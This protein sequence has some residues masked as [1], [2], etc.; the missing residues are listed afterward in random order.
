MY[1]HWDVPRVPWGFEKFNDKVWRETTRR[2]KVE[3]IDVIDVGL[4]LSLYDWESTVAEIL[5][6]AV[7]CLTWRHDRS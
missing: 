3:D 1:S 6:P 7:E 4:P 5:E 2:I